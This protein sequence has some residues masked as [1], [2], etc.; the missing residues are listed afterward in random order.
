LLDVTGV[1][2]DAAEGPAFFLLEVQGAYELFAGDLAQLD[3][4]AADLA[5]LEL[6]NGDTAVAGSGRGGG[7]SGGGSGRSLGRRRLC[8]RSG[9]AAG[10]RRGGRLGRCA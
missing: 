9:L 5:A 4:D 2:Q 6:I 10:G 8:R 1:D 7:G 3:Q